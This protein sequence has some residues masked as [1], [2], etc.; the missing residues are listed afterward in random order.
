MTAN[1]TRQAYEKKFQAQIDEWRA[2]IDKL[3]AKA[4]KADA[5]AR[6]KYQE[7]IEELRAMQDEA[8]SKL[9]KLRQAS[10]D[11]WLDIKKGTDRT[12]ELFNAALKSAA[13]RMK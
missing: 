12:W 3:R 6:I 10:D 4:A 11:A 5:N 2:E 9:E 1:E 8:A 13:S 7:K